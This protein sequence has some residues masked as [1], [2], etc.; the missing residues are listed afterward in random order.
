MVISCRTAVLQ[1]NSQYLLL[2]I[3]INARRD[4][5]QFV[6]NE[7]KKINTQ[8]SK[9]RRFVEKVKKKRVSSSNIYKVVFA[10]LF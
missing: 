9:E 2:N 5:F 4:T 7:N 1:K 3:L 6:R 10:F 8:E